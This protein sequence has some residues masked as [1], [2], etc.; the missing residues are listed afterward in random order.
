[1]DYVTKQCATAHEWSER[2]LVLGKHCT[3]DNLKAHEVSTP[4]DLKSIEELS[5]SA[6]AA[7]ICNR[8]TVCAEKETEQRSSGADHESLETLKTMLRVMFSQA[9]QDS[10]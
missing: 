9:D 6:Q 5:G 7:R 3:V 8:R 4:G 2:V 10:L 1:M